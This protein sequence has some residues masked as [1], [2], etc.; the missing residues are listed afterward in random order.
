ME[1][2]PGERNEP[3]NQPGSAAQPQLS[4]SPQ[5]KQNNDLQEIREMNF[6]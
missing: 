1:D 6:N 3:P 2:L 4:G 5:P